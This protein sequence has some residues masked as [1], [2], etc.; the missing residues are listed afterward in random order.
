MNAMDRGWNFPYFEG[1]QNTELY[2]NTVDSS[3]FT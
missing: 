1:M 2:L 3:G